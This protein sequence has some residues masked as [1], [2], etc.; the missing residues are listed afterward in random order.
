MSAAPLWLLL[1][2]WL[3][4]DVCLTLR[5]W[6]AVSLIAGWGTEATG[7]PGWSMCASD[8]AT[9][10]LPSAQTLSGSSVNVLAN[11]DTLYM[12]GTCPRSATGVCGVSWFGQGAAGAVG[13][14]GVGLVQRASSDTVLFASGV[15]Q[16]LDPELPMQALELAATQTAS[17]A[18][19]QATTATCD[20]CVR[21]LATA[22]RL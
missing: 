14:A 4:R 2:P 12:T 9:P 10:A 19:V 13:P 15:M 8:V 5:V 22:S 6:R 16:M 18:G 20:L 1:L 7:S 3:R 11:A 21:V 17:R